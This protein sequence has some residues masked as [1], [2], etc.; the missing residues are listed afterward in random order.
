MNAR[1]LATLVAAGAV[2]VS[3][4]PAD[5]APKVLKDSY[6]VSLPVPFP[7]MEDQPPTM[8]GCID[9][10]E[11]LS[12][13]SKEFTLP[14]SGGTLKAEVAYTG[15]W[16]LYLLDAK[17]AILAAAETVETGNTSAATEKLTWKKAKKGQK[18]TLVAC[19]WLGLK[20]GKVTFTY[21]YGK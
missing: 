2:A 6:A 5:A 18:V 7:V 16:D 12:K 8:Y 11:G 17:G 20:D 13:N 15:D 21:T 4:M 14:A 19:N 9:G 10:E 1:L 3:A